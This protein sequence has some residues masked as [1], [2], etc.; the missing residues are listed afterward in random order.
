MARPFKYTAE[1]I[2][3]Y[4][5]KWVTE[6]L[7]TQYYIKSEL[8]KSGERAGEQ[9]DIK[10]AKPPTVQG[11]CLF[12]DCN[13]QTFYDLMNKESGN[14]DSKLSDSITRV[15]DYIQDYQVGGAINGLYNPMLVARINGIRETIDVNNAVTVQALP[16]TISNNIIDLTDYDLKL[17]E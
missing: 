5:K 2:D 11:F 15:H 9:A 16:T 3:N 7:P 4:F 12:I 10:I 8:I 6:F 1:Q 17:N 14:V 13:K